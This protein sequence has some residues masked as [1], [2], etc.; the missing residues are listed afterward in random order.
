MAWFIA[1][2]AS[3]DYRCEACGEDLQRARN[4]EGIYEYSGFNFQIG[5]PKS[6]DEIKESFIHECPVKYITDW[7]RLIWQRYQELKIQKELGMVI[8][9]ISHIL[10]QACKVLMI[11][12]QDY[13]DF[14]RERNDK[15]SRTKGKS[16]WPTQR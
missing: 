7:S 16:K 11:A 4:C 8:K 5:I 12:I 9:P 10:F 13:D 14:E 15:K 2:K 1:S 3:Q 6:K